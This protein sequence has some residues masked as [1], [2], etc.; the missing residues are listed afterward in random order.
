MRDEIDG[1]MWLE[2]G[3]AFTEDLASLFRQIGEA[4]NRLTE[5]QFRAPWQGQAGC[6]S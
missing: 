5:I 6:R 1:R 2:H 4:L 3:A